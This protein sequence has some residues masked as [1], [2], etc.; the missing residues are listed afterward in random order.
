MTTIINRILENLATRLMFIIYVLFIVVTAFFISIGYYQELG[1]Q[2]QRQYDKLN[3]IVSALATN[4]DGDEHEFIMLNY[5]SDT[6]SKREKASLLYNKLNTQ[7]SLA[8]KSTGLNSPLYTL[9][10]NPT[11]DRFYYGVRSDEF[12]DIHN[13]YAQTPDLLIKNYNVGGILP[14]YESE[15][16]TWI[17]AFH[18]IK[19]T[20]GKVVALLEADIEFSQFKSIVNNH[21]LKRLIISLLVIG[22]IFIVFVRY[23]KKVLKEEALN[24]QQLSDQKRIIEYKNKDITDSMHYALKIQNKI[25]PTDKKFF[26]NFN[27]C[28]IF[29]Q[30]KDIVAGD[31]Y[32]MVE[33]EDDIYIAVADCTGHGVP[34][35][36]LSIICANILDT[37]VVQMDITDTAEILNTVRDKVITY[38]TK[39]EFAMN[40]G[41]DIAL[42]K[43]NLKKQVLQYSGAYNP[44]YIIRNEELI[45]TKPCKQPIGKFEFSKQFSSTTYELKPNDKVYLFTDGYADQFGGPDNKKFKFKK[46]REMLLETSS[47]QNMSEQKNVVEHI[48]NNWMGQEEQI[49]DVCVVG[50]KF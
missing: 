10:K 39:G 2:E 43:I 23:T 7:L 26:E 4:I 37:V 36:I 15:N 3:G 30:S 31:F 50:I 11:D 6:I 42:C 40:D 25:L 14:T 32:W 29:Y 49:D 24:K 19:T 17:S 33:K 20:S 9:I 1:L 22:A 28:F 18:P 41:M 48:F 21:F 46:F 34:G 12:I 16:G 5:N 47:S 35:A 44:I 45:S 27:D 13:V 38:L 8:Q